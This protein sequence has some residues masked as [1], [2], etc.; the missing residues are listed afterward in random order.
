MR[1]LENV[2]CS[3]NLGYI[4]DLNYSYSPES[5]ITITISFVNESGEYRKPSLSATTKHSITVGSARFSLYAKSYSIKKSS[6]GN[7]CSV[8]FVDESFKLDN[9][10]VVLTGRGCGKNIYHLGSPVDNRTLQ[11]KINDSLD[12]TAQKIKDFTQFQDLEY[13]FDEFISVMRNRFS[14]SVHASYDRTEKR[15]F[16]GTFREVL[17]SWC[18]VFNLAFFIE[19]GTVKIYDPTNL[20]ISFPVSV[21]DAITYEVEED[22][23][24]TYGKTVSNYF[25]QEGGEKEFNLTSDW[26]SPFPQA[27]KQTN[28]DGEIDGVSATS[29][30]IS[31]ITLYP[32]GYEFNLDQQEPDL[33]QVA[34]AM[35]GQKFWFLYNL[36]TSNLG[37]CGMTPVGGLVNSQSNLNLSFAMFNE[38]EFENKFEAYR[39]YGFDIAGK[40]YMS[41]KISDLTLLKEMRWYSE[42][43]GQIFKMDSELATKRQISPTFVESPYDE[44]SFID[45]T[46]VNEYFEGVKYNGNRIII[47]DEIDNGRVE[48]FSVSEELQN[49]ITK[50]FDSV[51][52][53]GSQLGIVSDKK[54]IAYDSN[55]VINSSA[56]PN[57]ISIIID[58][59]KNGQKDE[60]LK[61]RFLSYGI[62]GIKNL[63]VVNRKEDDIQPSEF[64]PLS[65]GPSILSN[66]SVVKAKKEGSHIIYYDKY[67]KCV[68]SSSAGEHFSHRFDIKNISVDNKLGVSFQKNGNIYSITRDY[69][70]INSLV[71]NPYLTNLSQ[72]RTFPTK[73]VSFSVNYFYPV[74]YN[75]LSNGLVSLSM[76]LTENGV[77]CSYTFSNEMLTVPDYESDF[78]K[79]EERVKNSWIRKNQPKETIIK[80]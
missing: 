65:S 2:T 68:S 29:N 48:N 80:K 60:Y 5:G 61:P 39:Y 63:D 55:F 30:G 58:S 77:T 4:Y 54:Y 22:L 72:S 51:F 6:D 18:S 67:S 71:N 34:A 26:D 25:Q 16:T 10:Y 31:H 43:E 32:I 35:Y 52:L 59:I 41:N 20:S 49:A 46:T 40:Y 12:P 66:T 21:T 45:K 17:S 11:E 57:E 9:Y 23:E 1:S 15:D 24:G 70:F 56:I 64:K 42:A 8:T 13:S 28:S 14:V 27:N 50:C 38:E 47:M 53:D 37:E 44:F 33:Q 62:K 76:S 75:F 36:A 79:Y 78:M 7:I 3:M 74:P 69:G 73:T 19:N